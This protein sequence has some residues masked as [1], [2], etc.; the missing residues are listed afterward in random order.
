MAVQK[1][2]MFNLVAEKDQ[3]DPVLR[4]MLLMGFVQLKSAFEDIN[5]NNF[6]LSVM[7]ENAEEIADL[8]EI[9]HCGKNPDLRGLREKLDYILETTGLEPMVDPEQ[10][11]GRYTFE[12]IREPVERIHTHFK[13]LMDETA[14]RR[15]QLQRLERFDCRNCLEGIRVDLGELAGLK[16]FSIRWGYLSPQN[17]QKIVRNYENI[18]AAVMHIGT[19]EDKELYLVVCPREIEAEADRILRSV[20]F[21]PIEPPS[22]YLDEPEAM[23]RKME[24]ARREIRARLKVLSEI[25]RDYVSGYRET[26]I[27]CHNRLLMEEQLESVKERVAATNHFFYLS[28]WIP[29]VLQVSIENYFAP[30]GDRVILTF[31]DVSSLP[32]T[33]VVPTRLRNNILFR[34]FEVLVHMY[35]TPSYDELDPTAF[36]GISYMLLFGAMFGDLGQG[37]V[38]L[39]AGLLL[40]SRSPLYGGILARLGCASM[41]FGF[42]F[43]SFFG[44]E[45]MISRFL[46]GFPYF[47]PMENINTVLGISIGIGIALLT[48]SYSFSI[49]NKVSRRE[50]EEG[51]LGRNGLAG[52]VLFVSILLAALSRLAGLDGIPQMPLIILAIT[53]AMAILL[54]EP[55]GS[56]LAG[57]RPLY[58]EAAGSYYVESGF[59]LFETFLSLL[60]NSV[61]FIRVGAF[62]LNHVGLFV[63]FHTMAQIIGTAAGNVAMFLIGNLMVICLEGLIVFIQGLRLVYYEMFSKYYKGEGVLFRPDTITGG[64]VK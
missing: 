60:S 21:E 39:L 31:R 15:E 49:I 25:A 12:E 42:I 27:R 35:G 23:L 40:Q 2:T 29:R 5:E 53:G 33:V 16:H 37:L 18:S 57:R 11:R 45:E 41:L 44:Y 47:R 22:E 64:M 19:Q 59:D 63:A 26:L 7:E 34:P 9:G 10:M 6:T 58:H 4:D 46:P 43:D 28:A 1:M 30:Y 48:L 62:T 54:R 36:F 24:H 3:L 61:S 38:L 17:R 32:E 14:L 55:L 8:V 13:E 56:L 50:W 51:L 20:E 52:L